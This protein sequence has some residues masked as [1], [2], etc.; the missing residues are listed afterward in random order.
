MEEKEEIREAVAALLQNFWITRKEQPEEFLLI[1]KHKVIVQ[2]YFIDNFGFRL[3]LTS[4]LIK[5][6]K[7]PY[8]AES[9]MGILEFTDK[10]DYSIFVAILSY[11]EDRASDD[12]FILNHLTKHVKDFFNKEVEIK[13]EVRHHRLAFVRAMKYAEK[14]D[15]IQ[16]LDGDTEKFKDDEE[17]EVLYQPTMLSKYY[18]RFFT[19]PLNE[20]QNM[21]ELLFDKWK[22]DVDNS[23]R[24]NLQSLNRRIFFSPV[25]YRNDL[26]EEE[27]KYFTYQSHRMVDVIA[28]FTDFELEMYQNELLLI[29]TKQKQSVLQYSSGSMI[30]DISL[31]FGTYIHRFINQMDEEDRP[32][33]GLVIN[34]HEF[35]NMMEELQTE[36]RYGWSKEFRTMYPEEVGEK[37]IAHLTE[38]K[39]GKEDKEAYTV[40]IYP[41]IMR[42]IG[43][44]PIEYRFQLHFIDAVEKECGTSFKESDVYVLPASVL[45]HCVDDFKD[46]YQ[47]KNYKWKDALKAIEKFAEYNEEANVLTLDIKQIRKR[48][49]EK[50]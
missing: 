29:E 7:I 41:S 13:W 35:D 38:W 19:K 11:L 31:Q 5:L 42:T 22:G 12:V 30:Y 28:E 10:M 32:H 49:G 26:T 50:S 17:Y 6:E 2:K 48:K 27:Q 34:R 18:L 16:V 21:E 44:Y 9:W 39:M 1:K 36:Y 15:L 37:L 46:K 24:I 25:V 40:T 47:Q 45:Q 43:E 4:N 3:F 8:E 23:P 20:F 33:F 14:M